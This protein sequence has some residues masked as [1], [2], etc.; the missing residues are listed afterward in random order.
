MKRFILAGIVALALAA[1]TEQQASAGFKMSISGGFNASMEC[2]GFC[3]TSSFN[4]NPVSPCYPSPCYAGS[5][6]YPSYPYGY[7]YAPTYADYNAAGT[8]AQ[9]APTAAVQSAPKTAPAATAPRP[10]TYTPAAIYPVGYYQN[11]GYGN[12]YNAN[13]YGATPAYWYGR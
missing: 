3:W 2:T 9:P 4:C 12:G 5:C 1:V 10:A 13:G 8:Y 6:G 11:M 7:A